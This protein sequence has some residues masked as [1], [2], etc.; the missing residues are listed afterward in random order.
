MTKFSVCSHSPDL[1]E[2]LY[3]S[4]FELSIELIPYLYF[5]KIGFWKFILSFCLEY[6]PFFPHFS[7]FSVLVSAFQKKQSSAPV[8]RNWSCIRRWASSI[9]LAQAPG[10]LSN[11]SLSKLLFYVLSGPS[12]GWYIKSRQ[13]PKGDYCSQHLDASWLE[14]RPS[15]SSW[16]TMLSNLFQEKSGKWGFLPA[17]SALN[18]GV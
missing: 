17:P 10:C 18:L 8:L 6:V 14:A 3:D 13:C 9:S 2:H 16:E 15:G 7:W 11:F 12:N 4:H 5:I 1:G